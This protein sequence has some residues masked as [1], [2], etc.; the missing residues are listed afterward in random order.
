MHAS[1]FENMTKCFRRYGAAAERKDGERAE[2][3]DVGG[4]DVNGSY[5][6]I[7]PA[8]KFRYRTA[9]LAGSEGVDVPLTDPYALP[10]EDGSIDVVISGQAFEHIEF[11][12]KT[13]A[14]M[15]RV[16]KPEGFIFLI[17]PSAGPEHRYPVDCYRFYPDAFTALAKSAGCDLVDVWLDERGPWRDLTGVFR[18]RGARRIV[19][20]D[21]A[22]SRFAAWTGAPGTAEE[23][24]ERGAVPYI[25]V[26]ARLHQALQPSHYLEIGV[27]H[28]RSLALATGKAT[29]V[30]PAPE[31]TVKLPPS[32]SVVAKESD[33][34]FDEGLL[35][36]PADLAFI[37]GLHLF[38][39]AL[40]DFMNV[41]RASVP[42]SALVIDDIFP[43]H[44][45]QAA[46]ARRTAHWTGDVWKLVEI[47]RK[48]RPDLH[49]S[50]LDTA[51]TGLALVAGLDPS[52]RVLWERYNPIVREFAAIDAPPA[53]VLTRESALDPTGEDFAVLV[54]L[55]AENARQ[56]AKPAEAVR[57][58]RGGRADARKKKLS[59]VVIAYNMAR[60]LP[61][62]IRSLSPSC[63]RGIA[64]EDYE[65]IVVDN[66]STAPFDEP[67]LARLAS[68]LRVLRVGRPTVSPVPA[69]ELGLGAARGDLVGVF[70]DGARMA[71]PGLLSMALAA[72]KLHARPVIGTIAFHLGPKVQSESILEGYDQKAE[73]DLLSASAWEQDGYRLFGISALAASSAGGWFALPSESNAVFMRAEHWKALGGYDPAF[74]APGG[75]L[76]NLDLWA[77]ACADPSG[78]VIMLLGEATFHQ[79]H[80]GVATNSRQS[81]WKEFHDEYVGIRGRA[82][83]PPSRQA[84][85]FGKPPLSLTANAAPANPPAAR[86]S[87]S[88][89]AR[90]LDRLGR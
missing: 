15:L 27:R 40:R 55:L 70:I 66:G 86:G 24:A 59:I 33:A 64:E 58:L 89:L 41:E 28:G 76:A 43:N 35:S 8:D 54:D 68:N 4:A 78:E 2:V 69:I 79:V 77:R 46:R 80:G 6:A 37:D 39:F 14:E 1:S 71:S 25:D 29:G 82:Y 44:P 57:K 51:P 75:G 32:A 42:G 81:R 85:Y 88:R 48:Y 38:E 26:L 61:R 47:L 74:R 45:A 23:E 52:N 18:H 83:A 49:V 7:F 62:T 90:L 5:R 3:L 34:F 84:L 36:A 19:P 73:D 63:Q 50:T 20:A 22:P 53:P 11:F 87:S 56:K 67:E 16:L 13:F 65:I 60:E 72:S 21:A 30:D 12:W 10:V 31:I 17:V 9:D